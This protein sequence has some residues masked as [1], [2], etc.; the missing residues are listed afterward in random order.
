[1]GLGCGEE[2]GGAS[3]TGGNVKTCSSPSDCAAHERCDFPDD[4][5]GMGEM[6][7]CQQLSEGCLEGIPACGCD[8][9]VY[10]SS[11]CAEIAGSDLSAGGGCSAPSGTF[12]CGP[13]FCVTP[14][15]YCER[16]AFAGEGCEGS[17]RFGCA[18]FDPNC[19]PQ[20]CSCL[21]G[22]TC[23]V[24][25]SGNPTATKTAPGCPP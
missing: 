22:L 15:G 13:L 17:E 20:D 1:M 2:T 6:G 7:T 21:P 24:D 11:G 12:A 4:R 5:C 8:G 14:G 9:I 3:S 19:A 16:T 23:E 10:E 18:F 25:A